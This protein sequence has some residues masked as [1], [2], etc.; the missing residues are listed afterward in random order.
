MSAMM[1][2]CG[3]YL[4]EADARLA[5]GEELKRMHVR[6]VYLLCGSHA[7]DTV[8][9]SLFPKLKEERISYV[10]GQFAGFPTRANAAWHAERIVQT[11]CDCVVG[12]GG[13][14]CMDTTK[15]VSQIAQI[16]MG[17]IPTQL[18][19]CASC[20]NVAVEYNEQ[21]VY[22]GPYFHDAPI[23]FVLAD[24]SLLSKAPERY[25]AAGIVDSMAKYPELLFSER[26]TLCCDIIDDAAL[27]ASCEMSRRSWNLLI[28]NGRAAYADN[29][30]GRVSPSFSAIT[31]LNLA[32]TGAISGLARGS[33]QLAIAHAFYNNSTY[34]F[35]DQWR[36]FL[37]GEI[38][39]VGMMIQL[40]MN[41]A[42]AEETKRFTDIA[43]DLRVPLS[44]RQL[45]IQPSAHTLDQIYESLVLR[46]AGL[47][48]SQKKQLCKALEVI[49]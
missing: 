5:L 16:R 40:T 42:S 37:H 43:S 47:S 14:K 45:E 46:F 24:L 48:D 7:V 21:G 29:R 25:I 28:E 17:M 32:V 35:P 39:S 33:R 20:A 13:G 8:A 38:V 18:A 41:G 49:A 26:G 19:T 12:I 10:V 3:R 31:H 9:P 23:S 44:L 11:D 15:M 22:I 4:Q 1:V 34:L 2:G 27:Q 36:A 6:K 30:A